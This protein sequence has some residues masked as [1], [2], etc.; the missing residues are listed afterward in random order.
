MKI[1]QL[2]NGQIE[3]ISGN[4][5]LIQ[6]TTPGAKFNECSEIHDGFCIS[7]SSSDARFK[8]LFVALVNY[9]NGL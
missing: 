9:A 6:T 8:A 3:V 7:V 2:E 4:L 1:T 5:K